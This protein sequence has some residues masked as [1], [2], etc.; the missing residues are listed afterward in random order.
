MARAIVLLKYER[1]TPLARW[2][3]A[4]LYQLVEGN[5]TRI[6][7]NMVV[8]VPLHPARQ[9][10][11]GYNQAEIIARPL[12]KALGIPCRTNIL[13]RTRSRPYRL[14]LTLR[15]R[16]ESVR[17]AFVTADRASVDKLRVLLVDDVLTSGATL[18]A[19]SRALRQAGAAYV[20]AVTVARAMP[21]SQ[22]LG[23]E[24]PGARKP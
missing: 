9:R 2:F 19:C 14:R 16:W 8:P 5:D 3:G 15:E 23:A 22:W 11:R 7:I 18:D 10:E 21:R 12:A 20:A 4:R 24:S 13:L 17:N 6:N 1:M